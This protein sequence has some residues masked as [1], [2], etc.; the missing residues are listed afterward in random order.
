MYVILI[1]DIHMDEKG[2]GVLRRTFKTCKKYLAHVQLS[3]FEGELTPSRH[4]MLK[5]ELEKIIR[6]EKDSVILF[7][8][9][10]D[11]W[12]RKEFWGKEDDLASN[13]F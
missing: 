1:Y 10:S 9:R 6:K 8:S 3:V 11:H 12:L 7:S 13:I 5:G 2:A 4:M